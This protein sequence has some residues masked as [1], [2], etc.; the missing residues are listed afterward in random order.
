MAVLGYLVMA[1]LL[2]AALALTAG[3]V[4]FLPENQTGL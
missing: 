1:I 4:Y 3:G 2:I